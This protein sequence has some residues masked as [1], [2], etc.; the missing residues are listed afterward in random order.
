MVYIPLEENKI[1][2]QNRHPAP[3]L[4][5]SLPLPHLRRFCCP[6]KKGMKKGARGRREEVRVV[7]RGGEND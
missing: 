1:V 7:C 6:P 2:L 4:P 5:P 3:S